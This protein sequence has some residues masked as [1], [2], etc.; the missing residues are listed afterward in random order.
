VFPQRAFSTAVIPRM[1]TTKNKTNGI[2]A[3]TNGTYPKYQT[4][5]LRTPITVLRASRT[6]FEIQNRLFILTPPC[7]DLFNTIYARGS[8]LSYCI[9]D[10][11]AE[12]TKSL[13][14]SYT[15]NNEDFEISLIESTPVFRR[16]CAPWIVVII[17]RKV[18]KALNDHSISAFKI[19]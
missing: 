5:A 18:I 19:I 14:V 3:L 13:P 8:I 7:Q 16:L 12:L 4:R 1:K 11:P 2:V 15:A 10:Y 17:K 6:Q 9:A